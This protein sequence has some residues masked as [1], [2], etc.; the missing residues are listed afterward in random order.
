MEVTIGTAI[1]TFVRFP[2]FQEIFLMRSL[3]AMVFCSL[4]SASAFAV[5]RSIPEPSSLYLVGIAAV[6]AVAV[7][8]RNRRK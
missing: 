1:A 7:A 8:V 6:A 4:A 5:D 3:L 2:H